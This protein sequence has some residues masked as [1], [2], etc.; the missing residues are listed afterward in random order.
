M[1][2]SQYDELRDLHPRATH[3]LAIDNWCLI[4]EAKVTGG[5]IDFIGIQRHTG[6]VMIIECKVSVTN[7]LR[8]VAQINAY[9]EALNAPIVEKLLM[10]LLPLTAFQVDAFGKYDI[11]CQ[12]VSM[13]TPSMDRWLAGSERQFVYWFQHWKHEAGESGNIHDWLNPPVFGPIAPEIVEPV[14]LRQPL[15]SFPPIPANSPFRS[16]NP[17]D[18]PSPFAI[19]KPDGDVYRPLDDDLDNAERY[20]E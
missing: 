17:A 6:R 16:K 9:H 2:K 15:R 19:S 20:A 3:L 11:K 5:R 1:T 12:T 4:N 14:P 18:W 13:D 8:V 10:T 7:V